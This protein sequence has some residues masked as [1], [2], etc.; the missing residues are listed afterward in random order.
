MEPSPATA[1]WFDQDQTFMLVEIAGGDLVFQ[2][3]S[4]AGRIVDS[5]LIHPRAATRT[6]E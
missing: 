4:R 5:G 3:I 1:A 6:G 2:T